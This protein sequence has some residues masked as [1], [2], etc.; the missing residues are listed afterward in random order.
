MPENQISQ[1]ARVN[2]SLATAALSARGFGRAAVVG[3][4]SRF[5]ERARLYTSTAGM[6]ADGFQTSDA[7]YREAVAHFGQQASSG[8]SVSDL[9]IIRQN[10]PVAQ[11]VSLAVTYAAAATYSVTISRKGRADVVVGPV[12]ADTDGATTAAAIRTAIGAAIA[13][14]LD[15]TLSSAGGTGSDVVLTASTAGIPF[16][17][18]VAVTGSGTLVQT[19]T[20]ANVGIAEDLAATAAEGFEWY[21]TLATGRGRREIV[22]AAV[23]HEAQSKIFL[24]ETNDSSVLSG[25][26]SASSPFADLPSELK[27]RTLHRTALQYHATAAE[28]MSAA[29]AGYALPFSPG[30]LTW[31]GKA[32]SGV[33][34]SPLSTS[35]LAVLLGTEQSPFSGKNANAYVPWST[36]T[37]R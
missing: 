10:A 21:A 18:S 11:V 32:L 33:T 29:W 13:A 5:P 4:H 31:W 28:S 22:E 24:A 6:L 15:D 26:Y 12:A 17:V 35:Q 30:T 2:V 27:A 7:E 1:V 14:G 3:Q 9:L 23:W 25:N 20:T 8:R 37:S 16:S 34:P 36:T 19:T